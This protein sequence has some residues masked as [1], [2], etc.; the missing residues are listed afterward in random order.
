MSGAH[1]EAMKMYEQMFDV[2]TQGVRMKTVSDVVRN[3]KSQVMENI[4]NKA[5]LKLGG[6]NYEVKLD[7]DILFIGFGVE[8]PG[9][10][11]A[12]TEEERNNGP[13]SIVGYAANTNE[14]PFEFVGDYR[15]RESRRD[16][17]TKIIRKIVASCIEKF[18]HNRRA[19]PKHVI[20]YRNGC[21]EGQFTNIIRFEVPLIY[22]ALQEQNC[23]AKVILIVSN[24]QQQDVRLFQ[25]RVNPREKPPEQNIKP[26]TVVDTH[27]VHPRVTEFYL[28]SHVALQ[29]S[30]RTP[31]YTVLVNDPEF[32]MDQLQEMTYRLCYGHQIVNMPTSLPSPVYIAL[33]YAKRGREIYNARMNRSSSSTEP[34]NVDDRFDYMSERYGYSNGRLANKRV[35]A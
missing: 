6:L 23:A 33:E 21:S 31:R 12:C 22:E 20:I 2:I 25:E 4:V 24:K 11:P 14:R 17:K 8:H 26:G 28:N 16:E 27:I 32:S 29:G 5:N 15:F 35:N 34:E 7:D 19:E 3:G 13:P 10:Q 18:M 9:G 1:L 30:A